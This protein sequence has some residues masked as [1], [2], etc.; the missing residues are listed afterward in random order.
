[1]AAKKLSSNRVRIRMLVGSTFVPLSISESEYDKIMNSLKAKKD[2]WLDVELSGGNIAQVK[3]SDVSFVEKIAETGKPSSDGTIPIKHLADFAGV[4]PMTITRQFADTLKQV[5]DGSRK[6]R[7]A[8]K[9]TAE[10]LRKHLIITR[11][12]DVPSKV[13]FMSLFEGEQK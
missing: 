10:N 5:S 12:A 4:H 8:T 6:F 7:R 3:L 13:D 1:M 9:K 11:G 2:A